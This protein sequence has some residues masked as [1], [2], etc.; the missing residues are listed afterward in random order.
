MLIPVEARE[1]FDV[2][3][4][5]YKAKCIDVRDKEIPTRKGPVKGQRIVW[6]IDVPGNDNVQYL[7]GKNYEATLAK[8]S[9]L[10][11]DLISWF[12]HDIKV[13]Q[14]DTATLKHLVCPVFPDGIAQGNLVGNLSGTHGVTP[15]K[16]LATTQKLVRHHLGTDDADDDLVT[17][18]DA[19]TGRL[20]ECQT[21]RLRPVNFPTLH[22]E[23]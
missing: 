5:R 19:S 22:R 4:G 15:H 10:R 6:E 3:P 18:D 2:E 8:N 16:H 13:R 20:L 21:I 14:F 9:L 12:G 17:A 1:S 23:D 7:V 11:N